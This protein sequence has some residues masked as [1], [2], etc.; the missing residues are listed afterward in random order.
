MH[1]FAVPGAGGNN[2]I[3]LSADLGHALSF[4]VLNFR[5]WPEAESN[6]RHRDFQ[7]LALPTELSGPKLAWGWKGVD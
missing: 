2:R 5:W 1:S 6:R 4:D 7:S 3:N